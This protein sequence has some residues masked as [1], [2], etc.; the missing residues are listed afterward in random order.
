MG[1]MVLPFNPPTTVDETRQRYFNNVDA[2]AIRLVPANPNCIVLLYKKLKTQDPWTEIERKAESENN[3][4]K[5]ENFPKRVFFEITDITLIDTGKYERKSYV[6]T[7]NNT[8]GVF[9][10]TKFTADIQ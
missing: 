8:F 7:L 6:A 10:P 2:Q 9:L 5:F 4:L 3:L 1:E